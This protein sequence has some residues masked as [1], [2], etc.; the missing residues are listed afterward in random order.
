MNFMS[1]KLPMADATG[2]KLGIHKSRAVPGGG[3]GEQTGLRGE[4]RH[5][6][7]PRIE[8]TQQPDSR[9]FVSATQRVADRPQVWLLERCCG[10]NTPQEDVGY[11]PPGLAVKCF[12]EFSEMFSTDHPEGPMS[13]VRNAEV[14]R[15]GP[16]Y[17][18]RAT[19]LVCPN[20]VLH[21]ICAIGW[22]VNFCCQD[23]GVGRWSWL[24]GQNSRL[25]GWRGA[26]SAAG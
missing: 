1:P 12:L 18:R 23:D 8:R 16:D 21:E 26:V 24:R 25:S 3:V 22:W 10:V 13:G 19:L 7:E 11:S 15:P 5:D 4:Q 17:F 2:E 14:G 6:R 20:P 9:R